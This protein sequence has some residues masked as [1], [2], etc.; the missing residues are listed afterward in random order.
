MYLTVTVIF[1]QKSFLLLNKDIRR[2]TALLL[3]SG[4]GVAYF[5]L[6]RFSMTHI[7]EVFV[8]ALIIYLSTAAFKTSEKIYFAF[9]PFSI[10]L[11]LLVKLSNFYIVLIP[12]IIKELLD[13]KIGKHADNDDQFLGWA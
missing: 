5:A 11:G 6:E 10:F 4:S 3:V 7:Y 13:L 2:T 12:L 8:N 9:I 1:L